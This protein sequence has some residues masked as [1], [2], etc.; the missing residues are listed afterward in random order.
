[1][2]GRWRQETHREPSKDGGRSW[3]YV[4][5]SQGTFGATRG[6]KKRGM[7]WPIG[8]RGSMVLQG[9]P[10]GSGVKN[11]PYNAGDENLIPGW[12]RCPVRGNGNALQYSSLGNPMDRRAWEATVHGVTNESDKTERLNNNNMAL[13]TLWFGIPASRTVRKGISVVLSHPGCSTYVIAATGN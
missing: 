5:P 9:C 8:F 7:I 3:N 2:E 13:Q 12:G 11:L 4:A 6:W 10:G 1:M